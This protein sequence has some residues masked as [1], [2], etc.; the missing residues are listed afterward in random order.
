M[1]LSP[2]HRPPATATREA[3]RPQRRGDDRTGG[4]AAPAPRLALRFDR[5]RARSRRRRHRHGLDARDRLDPQGQDIGATGHLPVRRRRGSRPAR[6]QGVPRARFARARG[7]QRDQPGGARSHRPGDHVRD[8]PA[9][10]Q[11]DP[12]FRPKRGAPGRQFDDRRHLP[13]D[14]ELDRRHRL[15]AAAVDDPQLRDHRQR[16]PL[17]QP[18]RHDRRSRPAKPP[19]HGRPGAGGGRGARGRAG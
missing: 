11:R 17:S 18:G 14:P 6:R 8:Q 4:G 5:D 15:R 10:R 19:A 13:A 16:D 12:P 7:R 1:G 2:R 3:D 9:Q